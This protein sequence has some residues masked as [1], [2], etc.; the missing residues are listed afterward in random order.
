MSSPVVRIHG[1]PA[2]WGFPAVRCSRTSTSS[3]QACSTERLVLSCSVITADR[4]R[5]VRAVAPLKA[6]SLIITSIRVSPANG[7]VWSVAA[8]VAMTEAKS[9][10]STLPAS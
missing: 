5:A 2:L 6:C 8:M 9:A 1:R 10:H 3:W 4:S 7:P